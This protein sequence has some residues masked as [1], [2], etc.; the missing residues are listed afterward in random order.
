MLIRIKES[1]LICVQFNDDFVHTFD[2]TAY[3]VDFDFART[4]WIR[5]HFAIDLALGIFG[6]DYLIPNKF[7]RRNSPI[8]EVHLN[9]DHQLEMVNGQV[10]SWFIDELNCYQKKAVANVLM[11][12]LLYPYLIYGPPGKLVVLLSIC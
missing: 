2:N 7:K 5:M 10:L 6:I 4:L 8:V 9:K 3:M 11:G 12:D 1:D